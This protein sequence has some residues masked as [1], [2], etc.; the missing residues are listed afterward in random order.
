[1]AGIGWIG[2]CA[3]LITKEYG[4]AIRISSVLTDAV[5]DAGHPVTASKCGGCMLCADA[6]P[7][8]AVSGKEWDIHTDRDVFFNAHAC[9]IT[10]RELSRAIGIDASLCGMCMYICP[11]TQKYITGKTGKPD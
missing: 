8:S 2:K 7:A 9:R 11:W 6:C 5:L 1:M 10:A 3:L 4:A